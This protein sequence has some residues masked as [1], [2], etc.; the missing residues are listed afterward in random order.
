M[1][2]STVATL[3]SIL[4]VATSAAMSEPVET[5]WKL[6]FVTRLNADLMKVCLARDRADSIQGQ[7]SRWRAVVNPGNQAECQEIL[8][9]DTGRKV[10]YYVA[11][12]MKSTGTFVQ[13]GLFIHCAPSNHRTPTGTHCHSEFFRAHEANPR[14]RILEPVLVRE[15]VR[16]SG[17]VAALE[18]GIQVE[19]GRLSARRLAAYR[20]AFQDAGTLEAIDTFERS[21]RGSDPEGLIQQLQPLKST[22]LLQQYRRRFAS[23]RDLKEIEAFIADYG[24]N[25]PDG[26]LPDARKRLAE[27]Q[28]KAEAEAVRQAAEK[29]AIRKHDELQSLEREIGD[30]KRQIDFARAAIERESRIGAISGYE[31]KV[32]LREAGERIVGCEDRIPKRFAQYK[33]LGGVKSLDAIVFKTQ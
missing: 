30:C 31:N 20:Q 25:D 33:R 28:R 21:Y 15:A 4:V 13:G 32:I 1:R 11:P 6:N 5:G 17:L 22:L 12:L 14:Y 9:A 29:E 26:R 19:Q 24:M 16:E 3:G 27:E 8:W 10:L 18:T 23:M 7:R 2:A